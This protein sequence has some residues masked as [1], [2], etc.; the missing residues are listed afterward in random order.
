MRS[1]VVAFLLVL[2]FAPPAAAAPTP[3]AW[4]FAKVAEWPLGTGENALGCRP[5]DPNDPPDAEYLWGAGPMLLSPGVVADP[6]NG[7]QFDI[8]AKTS[9]PYM[10][11]RDPNVRCKAYR[12]LPS[13]D[14]F[15]SPLR[16]TAFTGEARTAK[17]IAALGSG[18]VIGV[19]R[20]VDGEARTLFLN[21]DPFGAVRDLFEL[22]ILPWP[23]RVFFTD[24]RA[25][26]LRFRSPEGVHRALTPYETQGFLELHAA[27]GFSKRLGERKLFQG[28]LVPKISKSFI[29]FDRVRDD[30]CGAYHPVAD[31]WLMAGN[32]KIV[33]ARRSLKSVELERFLSTARWGVSACFGNDGQFHLFDCAGSTGVSFG[34]TPEGGVEPFRA[35]SLTLPPGAPALLSNLRVT[36][37]GEIF[38]DDVDACCTLRFL[39]DGRLVGLKKGLVGAGVTERG[40][41]AAAAGEDPST[42]PLLEF[43]LALNFKRKV[44]DLSTPGD[45]LGTVRILGVDDRNRL[46]L[47]RFLDGGPI[48][49]VL[50]LE[51]G[52]RLAERPLDFQDRP[53]ARSFG[54]GFALRH[55]GAV[56]VLYWDPVDHYTR[57]DYPAME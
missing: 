5:A 29:T 47:L 18:V 23:S 32:E 9:A 36:R 24:D 3:E 45:R 56:R 1:C 38:L 4:G 39:P 20:I 48:Q 30:P 57:L 2:A 55:D 25:A 54:T 40:I 15:I 13:G 14:L 21:I 17:P 16:P 12:S 11:G 52:K 43:G 8:A 49:V 10:L 26:F 37:T 34:V 19:N 51:T 6:V 53:N 41:F 50:D 31:T 42:R 35:W 27:S 44:K 46:H 33:F 7:R 28:G 22:P